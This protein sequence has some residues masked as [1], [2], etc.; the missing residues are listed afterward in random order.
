MTGP[1]ENSEF[2]FPSTFNVPRGEASGNIE[3]RGETIPQN[4]L[5]PVGPVINC[6]V[7]SPNSKRP[8]TQRFQGIVGGVV[9]TFR[10]FV[11]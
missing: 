5:F 8:L 3:G 6:F 7:M 4:L 10:V 11:A 9:S 2:C 1:K